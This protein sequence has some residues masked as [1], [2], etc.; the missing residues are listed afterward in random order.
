[1]G[2]ASIVVALDPDG[3]DPTPLLPGV[4]CEDFW[5]DHGVISTDDTDDGPFARLLL[6]PYPTDPRDPAMPAS[7]LHPEIL[8]QPRSRLRSRLDEVFALDADANLLHFD[9]G[10]GDI[11]VQ[12]TDVL[13]FRVALDEGR[14]LLWQA[15]IS[16]AIPDQ[17]ESAVIL[18]DRVTGTSV[19]LGTTVLSYTPD[20]AYHV[21]EGV[22]PLWFN[23]YRTVRLFRLPDLSVVDLPID[24]EY[25]GVIDEHRVLVRAR[26]QFTVAIHDSLTDELTLPTPRPGELL[27]FT[28]ERAL[29][30]LYDDFNGGDGPPLLALRF[31]GSEPRVAAR[32]AHQYARTYGDTHLVTPVEDADPLRSPLA[33]VDLDDA[34]EQII[35]VLVPPHSFYLDAGFGPDHLVYSVDDGDRSG[36][37]VVRLPAE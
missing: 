11:T 4:Q 35:D 3:G 21:A 8:H 25:E 7:V 18:Q 27:D 29:F 37:Y 36:I 31:D 10:S 12:A 13:D 20:A 5:S 17:T 30:L 6:Y 14:Y 28:P 26:N 19:A 24:H 15:N 2:P 32:R 34:T 1:V 23:D 16:P 9:L 33:F 22:V